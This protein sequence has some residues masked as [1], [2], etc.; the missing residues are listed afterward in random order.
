MQET[1]Y[2]FV[3]NQFQLIFGSHCTCHMLFLPVRRMHACIPGFQLCMYSTYTLRPMLYLLSV[4]SG[5]CSHSL[6]HVRVR[7]QCIH[8]ALGLRGCFLQG[9]LF[10]R[11][12]ETHTAFAV[13]REAIHVIFN[14]AIR[15]AE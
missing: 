2:T 5:P 1:F 15:T 7:V 10:G 14:P 6:V 4:S 13:P 8:P 12:F 9:F 3:G 11:K